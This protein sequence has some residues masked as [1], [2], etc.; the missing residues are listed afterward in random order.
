MAATKEEFEKLKLKRSAAQTAFTRRA[1]Y[2]ISRANALGE[3]EMVGE[4]KY[5]KS[6]HSRVRDAGFEYITA[7]REAGDDH[8]EE[9]A[10]LVDE[11]TADCDRKF[12]ETEQIVLMSFWTRFA[13]G[14]IIT[15]AREAKSAIDEAEKTD[16]KQKTRK[17]CDLM[18]KSLERDI[19]ELEK[20]INDWM[21]LIP[22]PKLTEIKDC[23]R[24]LRK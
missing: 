18:N 9:M 8:V 20:E 22:R 21:M 14:S 12:D 3:D 4:W 2:L 1:N 5:F 6:D 24:K 11:K 16:Y 10:V 7:L 13:E 19:V 23:F 17:Q 15:L